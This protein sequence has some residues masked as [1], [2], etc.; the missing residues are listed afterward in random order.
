MFDT[1]NFPF[2]GYSS[3]T[4]SS[5]FTSDTLCQ[6]EA[7]LVTCSQ[8]FSEEITFPAYGVAKVGISLRRRES[9]IDLQSAWSTRRTAVY[10]AFIERNRLV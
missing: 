10:S 1:V 8:P 2:F 7:V 5:E 6:T 4:A 3:I 9:G